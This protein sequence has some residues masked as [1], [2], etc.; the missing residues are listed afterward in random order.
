MDTDGRGVAGVRRRLR[1]AG[2]RDGGRHGGCLRRRGAD[3]VH[4]GRAVPMVGS[5]DG[6]GAGRRDGGTGPPVSPA[7]AAHPAPRQPGHRHAG[8]GVRQCI[9]QSAG[10][11][12][13][14]HAAGYPGGATDG[15]RLRRRRQRRAVPSGSA[16][17]RFYPASAHHRGRRPQRPRVY[18]A[19]GYPPG[20]VAV[21]GAVG[22][23][24]AAG[25]PAFAAALEGISWTLVPFSSPCC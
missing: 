4:G 25:R 23:G 16:E 8:G 24:G 14:R 5:H 6:H 11:G 13:R 3:A 2:R 12:Q 18:R 9:R 7:A 10:A 20:G 1:C 19:A 15:G 21:I 17:H 22:G